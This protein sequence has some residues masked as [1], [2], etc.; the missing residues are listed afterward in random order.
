[1]APLGVK[2]VM[3]SA[4]WPRTIRRMTSSPDPVLQLKRRLADE[5]LAL[6]DGWSQTWAAWGTHLSASRISEIRRGN[7]DNVSLERL[8]QAL[9][10]LGCD[11]DI[12]IARQDNEGKP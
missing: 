2:V 1:L 7:L 12:V 3:V 8:I 4:A 11:V 10:Y 5:L 9:S 6:M